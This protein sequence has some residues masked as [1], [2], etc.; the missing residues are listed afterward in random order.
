M[1]SNG[2]IYIDIGMQG[3]VYAILVFDPIP[4]NYFTIKLL[5]THY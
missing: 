4:L 2:A 5:A 3:V 1:L